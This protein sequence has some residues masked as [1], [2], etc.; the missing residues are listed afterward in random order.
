MPARRSFNRLFIVFGFLPLWAAI[1]AMVV[2]SF[3]TTSS[4]DAYWTVAPWLIVAAIPACGVTLIISAILAARARRHGEQ[5]HNSVISGRDLALLCATLAVLGVAWWMHSRN[6][7]RELRAEQVRL[8]EYVKQHEEVVR[9]FGNVKEVNL[10]SS[11]DKPP[12]SYSVSILV[13]RGEAR[14]PTRY[15][16][17]IVA[18]RNEGGER[19]F[20]LRCIAPDPG[21]NCR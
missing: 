18:V 2:G 6:E 9:R 4:S 11:A 20:A 17:A 8:I 15:E 5:A 7:A 14:M 16:Y 13:Q 12:V 21:F 19:R 10:H 3:L 1:V